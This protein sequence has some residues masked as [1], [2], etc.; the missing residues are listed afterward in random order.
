MRAEW[1]RTAAKLRLYGYTGH[2]NRTGA[3][4]WTWA[5]WRGDEA[6][7]KPVAMNATKREMSARAAAR[8]WILSQPD[9]K[10]A[11]A[12][13]TRLHWNGRPFEDSDRGYSS[14]SCQL[15]PGACGNGMTGV[16]TNYPGHRAKINCTACLSV[17]QRQEQAAQALPLGRGC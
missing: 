10:A 15:V 12:E 16:S 1:I 14:S 2:V 5:V 6:H 17:L 11:H 9:A 13:A 3:H 7:G 8:R 4:Q